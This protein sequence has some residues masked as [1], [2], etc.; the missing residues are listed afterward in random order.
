MV[1]FDVLWT[2]LHS[3]SRRE[4]LVALQVIWNMQPDIFDAWLYYCVDKM[5]E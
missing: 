3:N 4:K 2:Y 1:N 5:K